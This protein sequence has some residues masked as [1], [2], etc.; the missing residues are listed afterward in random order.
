MKQ[1]F[2]VGD[3][4]VIRKD[5]IVGN[6]YKM[7]HNEEKESVVSDM[8]VFQGHEAIIT[9]V[10]GFAYNIDVDGGKW[11]WTDGM[12]EGLAVK[13]VEQQNHLIQE[14]AKMEIFVDRIIF[15][16]PATIMFYRIPQ[17]D[18]CTGQFISWSQERKVVAKCN[19]SVGDVFSK[20]RGVDVCLLKAMRKEVD[21]ALAKV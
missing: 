4:V 8:Q 6:Y 20:Q 19:V 21:K 11:H 2:K 3:K 9:K 7:E 5:L 15:N 18:S 10:N 12:F 16:E 17:L 1:K 14:T 13:K